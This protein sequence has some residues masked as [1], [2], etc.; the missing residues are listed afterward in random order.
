MNTEHKLMWVLMVA[1]LALQG[2]S[3][4]IPIGPAEVLPISQQATVTGIYAVQTGAEPLGQIWQNARGLQVIIW[5]GAAS[6]GEQLWNFACLV[7]DCRGETLRYIAGPG[8]AV[9]GMRMS[10][11]VEYLRQNGWTQVVGASNVARAI[12]QA[13]SVMEGAITG[14][15]VVPVV[16]PASEPGAP[17]QN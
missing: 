2:C 16:V 8:K 17:V 6:E 11:F 1:L 12:S 4:G 15:L 7:G 5:P 10:M 14:W 13:M 3:A 9:S